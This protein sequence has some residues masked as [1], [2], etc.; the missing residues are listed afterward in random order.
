MHKKQLVDHMLVR[1]ALNVYECVCMQET[2][3]VSACVNYSLSECFARRL[4]QCVKSLQCLHGCWISIKTVDT[5]VNVACCVFAHAAYVGR[6]VCVHVRGQLAL[7]ASRSS[8][9]VQLPFCMWRGESITCLSLPPSLFLLLMYVFLRAS[10]S[11]CVVPVTW[12][13]KSNT[14]SC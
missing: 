9:Q 14:P 12:R 6:C 11:K 2:Q 5:P 10:M 4:L 8:G 13:V 7:T 1:C 3:C